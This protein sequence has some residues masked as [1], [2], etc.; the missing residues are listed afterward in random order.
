[1]Q[2]FRIAAAGDRNCTERK[3]GSSR[4]QDCGARRARAQTDRAEGDGRVAAGNVGTFY[5]G[6]R[7]VTGRQR[8]ERVIDAG[9]AG[10]DIRGDGAADGGGAEVDIFIG[11]TAISLDHQRVCA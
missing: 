2:C 10:Q 6:Q 8:A 11:I 3:T 9:A 7:G 1:M 4:I 5:D